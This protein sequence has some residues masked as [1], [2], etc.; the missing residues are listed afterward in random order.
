MYVYM[1]VCV[2][3]CVKHMHMCEYMHGF[4]I[5]HMEVHYVKELHMY[6]VGAA[7]SLEV[8]F[9]ELISQQLQALMWGRAAREEKGEGGVGEIYCAYSV[10]GLPRCLIF[11]STAGPAKPVLETF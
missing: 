9:L 6:T 5:L 4:P 1:R 7:A 3:M 8:L 11:D 2:F 10:P